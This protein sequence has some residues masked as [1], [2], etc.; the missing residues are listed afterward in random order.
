MNTTDDQLELADDGGLETQKTLI[1]Q[2]LDQIANEVGTAM[3]EAQLNY[4]IG[5][6]VPISGEALIAM[7]TLVDP[8]DEDW[9]HATAIVRRIVAKRL[10][11]IRLRSRPLSC[12]MANA[13]M[14]ASELTNNMLGFDTR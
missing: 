2:S 12:A 3:R 13:P 6:T 5:L 10:D 14:N 1:R 9:S 8:S 11:D 7:V 4:P